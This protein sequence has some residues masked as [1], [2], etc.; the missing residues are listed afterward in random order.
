MIRGEHTPSIR[1]FKD[2]ENCISADLNNWLCNIYFEIK[3]LPLG[4]IE[5][6]DAVGILHWLVRDLLLV[7]THADNDAF[8]C[9]AG[10][11]RFAVRLRNQIS[12]E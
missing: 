7:L 3:H 4:D 8:C 10:T 9:A 6:N 1:H 12:E 11:R 5:Q 2:M